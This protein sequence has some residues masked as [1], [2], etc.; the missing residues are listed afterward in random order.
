MDTP[1]DFSPVA[2]LH[3]HLCL[4]NSARRLEFVRVFPSLPESRDHFPGQKTRV[5]GFL[6]CVFF[7]QGHSPAQAVVCYLNVCVSHVAVPCSLVVSYETAIPDCLTPS[8][9]EAE[10]H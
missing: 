4:Q 3:L 9:A 2:P 6:A 8:W 1:T 5:V 10:I 7:H